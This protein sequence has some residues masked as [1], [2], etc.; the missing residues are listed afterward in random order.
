MFRGGGLLVHPLWGCHN[1]SL[2]VVSLYA[3]RETT[4]IHVG[5]MRVAMCRAARKGVGKTNIWAPVAGICPVTG[6]GA[7]GCRSR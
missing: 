2:P 7:R 5:R 6:V 3:G 1:R 4:W